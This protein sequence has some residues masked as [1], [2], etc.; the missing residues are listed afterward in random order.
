MRAIAYSQ[1]GG[2]DVISVRDDVAE[3]EIGS[4]DALV[5]VAYAGLN[6]AD[7]LERRG[8]YAVPPG[9]VPTPGIE[10]SGVVRAIGARVTSVALGDRVCGLVVS[11]AHAER[12][13]TNALTLS[14]VPSNVSLRVAAA[15]PEA[16]M[17]AHDA[18]FTR[19]SFALGESVVIHAVGSSVG[20]AATALAKAA[21]G[22]TLG[23]SRPQTKLDRAREHG[24][25]SGFIL[26]DTWV[27]KVAATTNGRGADVILD[28]V[29]A[30]MLD[31]NLRAL[32]SLGR[33]VQ[34][35]TMGG[36]AGAI[37]LGMLMGKRAALHGT[38]LRLRPIEEKIALAKFFSR[39]I[40]P[41]IE[42]GELREEI[43]AVFPL[44][45]MAQAHEHMEADKNFG[46]IVIEVAGE[47]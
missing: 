40:L 11:G 43:D 7:I 19:G 24:L 30:P 20:L 34:I 9:G 15:V 36:A 5:E 4:D 16:F 46:K 21:G 23:T 8:L 42:R 27:S 12:L 22:I 45:R 44:E 41:M 47:I 35:G 38:M 18:L 31:D 29:G 13:S 33:I 26:D 14:K 17:T 28:F 32:A 39:G 6:R 2:T 1:P 10:Y 25:A 3:P 37:N